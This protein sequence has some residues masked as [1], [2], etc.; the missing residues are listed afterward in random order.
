MSFVGGSKNGNFN[1]RFNSGSQKPFQRQLMAFLDSVVKLV[2]VGAI[3]CV[4]IS[5]L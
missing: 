4:P 5:R 3:G 2:N 1:A